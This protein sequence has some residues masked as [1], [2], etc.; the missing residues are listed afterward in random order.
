MAD[1]NTMGALR[2]DSAAEHCTSCGSDQLVTHA[3][4]DGTAWTHELKCII[5]RYVVESV[6]YLS[7]EPD[8]TRA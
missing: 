8:S 6:S 3:V 5:C 2:G 4:H 1:D 7:Q